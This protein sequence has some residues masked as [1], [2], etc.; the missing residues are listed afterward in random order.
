MGKYQDNYHDKFDKVYTKAFTGRIFNPVEFLHHLT[1]INFHFECG[2]ISKLSDE[3]INKI[4][5]R[6]S[7]FQYTAKVHGLVEKSDLSYHDAFEA[8]VARYGKKHGFGDP[9]RYWEV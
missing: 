8:L 4:K 7:F 1:N 2:E 9:E 5:T 3:G 6:F